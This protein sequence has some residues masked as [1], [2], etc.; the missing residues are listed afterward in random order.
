MRHGTVLV[1]GG[2]KRIGKAICDSL[3]THGWQVLVH[4]REATNPLCADFADEDAPACLFKKACQLAPDLCAIVNNASAFS[5]V[6][7][8]TEVE[9][10][11]LRN[12]NVHAPVI[13]TE[14]LGAYLEKQGRQG[15]VVNLLDTR[16]LGE[17]VAKTPYEATKFALKQMTEHQALKNGPTLRV[18]AVA[19][20]PVLLPTAVENH[21]PGGRIL[22]DRRPSPQ[23]VAEAVAFLLENEAVT[24]QTIAVD[25]GQFLLSQDKQDKEVGNGR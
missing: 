9:H 12:V 25:S 4:S 22:L 15:A 13:L 5:L 2:A 20:G 14:L 6:T 18:N 23:D 16:I 7:E 11:Y 3:R 1:T 19:P 21:E 17:M 24:G 8:M 10:Q